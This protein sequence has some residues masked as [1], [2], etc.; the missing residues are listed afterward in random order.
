[1]CARGRDTFGRIWKLVFALQNKKINVDEK[2]SIGKICVDLCSLGTR[3][4]NVAVVHVEMCCNNNLENSV[5]ISR[6]ASD[7][8]NN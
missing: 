2:K 4:R 7:L 5:D 1:M 3:R 8:T 6:N